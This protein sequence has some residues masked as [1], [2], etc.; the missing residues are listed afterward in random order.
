MKLNKK[1]ILT[2]IGGTVLLSLA[3]V[4]CVKNETTTTIQPTEQPA[5]D[6]TVDES[7]EVDG[8][9]KENNED[10]ANEDVTTDEY[11][12]VEGEEVA[13]RSSDLYEKLIKGLELPATMSLDDNLIADV[14]GLNVDDVVSYYVGVPMMNVHATELGVFEIKD[15][16]TE[17]I[18][19]A[20]AK[21]Q[22]NLE[23]TWETYL[24]D[25]YELVKNAK[26]VTKGGFMIYVINE[27]SDDIVAKFESILTSDAE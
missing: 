4:G 15:G 12:E 17:A 10:V 25:Q 14:Y 27:K 11:V 18:E 19:K 7:L 2:L 23:A 20:I 22:E 13:N 26:V 1:V 9:E 5:I 6:E 21:R 3:L 24:P 16:N 8:V